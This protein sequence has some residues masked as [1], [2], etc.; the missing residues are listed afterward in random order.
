MQGA[1][2]MGSSGWCPKCLTSI[3]EG[4]IL[5]GKLQVLGDYENMVNQKKKDGYKELCLNLHSLGFIRKSCIL[6]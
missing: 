4:D 2:Q 1:R 3:T 6:K 5:N